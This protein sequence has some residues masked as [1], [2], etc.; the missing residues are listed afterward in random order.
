VF[1]FGWE[2]WT[3]RWLSNVR[4]VLRRY[5]S[6]ESE[7]P[8]IFA[9]VAAGDPTHGTSALGRTFSQAQFPV[10]S[11]PVT[12]PLPEIVAG[13]NA[14]QPDVL[15][16]Y[17]SSLHPLAHEARAGRLRIRP[18]CVLSTSEPLL[19]EV[20]RGLEDTWGVAVTNCWSASEAGGMAT[21]CE[22]G[23]GMH[24][25][26]DLVVVE[27]VD[28]GGGEVSAGNPSA[29]IYVTNLYNPTLPLIRYEITDQVTVLEGA[30]GCGSAHRRIDD[31][32]GRLDD[33][34]V[35]GN[36]SVNP[37]AFESPLIGDRNVIEYQVRQTP[38]GA[39]VAVRSVGPLDSPRLEA[40]IA[41]NLTRLGLRGAHVEVRPV[42]HMDR[43][44]TGK[45]KRF[46]PLGPGAD[47]HPPPTAADFP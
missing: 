21:S 27:P 1:V 39:T 29:K 22:A 32:R 42:D 25:S 15:I 2:A 34:F 37:L 12:Q 26:D 7:S 11:F 14:A 5:A 44:R 10:R 16:G 13:L 38:R 45:L 43:L 23:P 35:Y 20:R 19:P 30:C 41:K 9:K 28:A 3:V 47:R 24:L 36:V 17:P 18:R 40:E 46:V 33:V 6:S 4:S 8:V 31:V